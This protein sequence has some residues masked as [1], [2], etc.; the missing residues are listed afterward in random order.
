VEARQYLYAVRDGWAIVLVALVVGLATGAVTWTLVPEKYSATSQIFV[1]TAAASGF[2]AQGG[3][4]F[5]MTRLQSYAKV[6]KGEAILDGTIE[7]LDLDMDRDE[8]ADSIAAQPLP[9]SVLMDITVTDTD[10]G[11]ARATANELAQQLVDQVPEL[12]PVVPESGAEVRVTVI[13]RAESPSPRAGMS[14]ALMLTIGAVLGL[15]VGLVSGLVCALLRRNVRAAQDIREN[16]GGPFLAGSAKQSSQEDLPIAASTLRNAI[17]VGSEGKVSTVLFV[18]LGRDPAGSTSL[19][20]AVGRA[21]SDLGTEVAIVEVDGERGRRLPV[22][23]RERAHTVPEN[24][25]SEL[26]SDGAVL[27]RQTEETQFDLDH[28]TMSRLADDVDI[29]LLL[30]PDPTKSYAAALLAAQADGAIFLCTFGA[31]SQAG[32]RGATGAVRSAG[33]TILGSYVSDIPRH[34]LGRGF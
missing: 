33:A 28:G 32:L 23:A 12:E 18:D 1:S 7:S 19:V 8:L 27:Q 26:V 20:S 14:L 4:E 13:N 15:L 5:A 9:N 10:A 29:V 6:I 34:V 3:S 2:D 17:K 25:S 21:F 31:T 30:A 16:G 11:R 24:R 22:P